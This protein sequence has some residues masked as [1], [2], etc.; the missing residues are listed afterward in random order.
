MQKLQEDTKKKKRQQFIETIKHF[1]L[2]LLHTLQWSIGKNKEKQRTNL[3]MRNKMC[4]AINTLYIPFRVYRLGL[5]E[6]I[7]K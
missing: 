2:H 3:E 7:F 5:A 6:Q 4:M 1:V